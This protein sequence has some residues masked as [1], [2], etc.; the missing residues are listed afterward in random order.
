MLEN[1][2]LLQNASEVSLVSLYPICY[3]HMMEYKLRRFKS[4]VGCGCR[5]HRSEPEEQAQQRLRPLCD[6][7]LVKDLPDLL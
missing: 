4:Q 6:S 7:I 5:S 1:L 2:L 3:I